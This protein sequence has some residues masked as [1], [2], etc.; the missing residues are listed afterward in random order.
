MF[1]SLSFGRFCLAG[2]SCGAGG[3]SHPGPCATNGF[4]AGRC[5]SLMLATASATRKTRDLVALRAA[6]GRGG[7]VGAQDSRI[8]GRIKL[9]TGR[10][11][12]G[13]D[14]ETAR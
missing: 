6:G 4:G 9:A 5:V 14:G 8:T 7:S 13:S 11:E 10:A 1:D 2:P 3:F 12:L